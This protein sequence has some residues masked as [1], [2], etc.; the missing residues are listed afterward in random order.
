MLNVKFKIVDK[1]IGTTIAMPQYATSGSA[2]I[3]LRA[4]LEEDFTLMP[5]ATELIRTGIS[6]YIA[7][8]NYAALVIPRSGIGHRHGIVLGNAIGLIDS[9]YQGEL[10]VSSWNR[11]D[12]PYTISVGERFAQLVFTRVT[13]PNMELVTEFTPTDRAAGGFG[14]TGKA[15]IT[16][17]VE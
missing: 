11:S 3:D 2:G 9:D 17:L 14:S 15:D 12:K 10:M 6:I 16:T 5:G 8:P 13:Q 1:K 4:C 7:D